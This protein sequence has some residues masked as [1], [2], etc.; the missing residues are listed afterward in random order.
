[1]NNQE[2]REPENWGNFAVE[3]TTSGLTDLMENK[4]VKSALAR[5]TIVA[6]LGSGIGTSTQGLSRLC[7]NAIEVHSV[8]F[9]FNELNL[10]IQ[11]ELKGKSIH[12]QQFFH[13]FL[14]EAIAS[15]K[16][17]DLILIKSAPDHQL[18]KQNGYKLLANAITSGG[19]V[20]EIA[21]TYLDDKEMEQ[22][23]YLEE[24]VGDPDYYRIRAWIKK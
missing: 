13:D 2:I 7:P 18:N 8:D 20:I 11:K 5:A 9:S 19:M 3:K 6:D 17:I 15:R 1:M 23:F 21:D 4:K 24:E 12:H 10:E 22:Y 16:K 14:R